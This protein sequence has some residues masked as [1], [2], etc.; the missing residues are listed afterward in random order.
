MATKISK[1]AVSKNVASG[2]RLRA[3]VGKALKVV[4]GGKAS[5]AKAKPEDE[6]SKVVEVVEK[7]KAVKAKA[8]KPLAPEFPKAG[9]AKAK[10]VAVVATPVA[11][12][13]PVAKP[14]KAKA[15]KAKVEAV[16]VEAV[17]VTVDEAAETKAADAV[18]EYAEHLGIDI[19]DVVRLAK[20]VGEYHVLREKAGMEITDRVV[21]LAAKKA[22]E[23]D[24]KFVKPYSP[25]T[26]LGRAP[27]SKKVAG[28]KATKAGGGEGKARA[29]L[30]GHA[31]TAVIR[32]LKATCGM[33]FAQIRNVLDAMGA[34]AIKDT[35]IRAQMSGGG[36]RHGEPA[37]LTAEQIE[38]AKSVA[39]VAPA[40]C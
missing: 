40:A 22:R 34:E 39:A 30:F 27:A 20:T 33:G 31:A 14:K 28:G 7:A 29:T 15:T 23:W 36:R 38:K 26:G 2:K 1:T 12:V 5:K 10:P 4:A 32:A 19:G 25:T 13:E 8:A 37:P 16:V 35:T 11:V 24:A 21:W 6:A 17:A 18:Y 9:K 3:A